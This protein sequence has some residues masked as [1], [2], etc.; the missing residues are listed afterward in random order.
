MTA[1]RQDAY[2]DGPLSVIRSRVD[3]LGAWLA[4]WAARQEPEPGRRAGQ[5]HHLLG[6][7][8]VWCSDGPAA[9]DCP[10]APAARW[11]FGVAWNTPVTVQEAR[12]ARH[13]HILGCSRGV[14]I[15]LVPR[16][17]PAAGQYQRAGGIAGQMDQQPGQPVPAAG[18]HR[19]AAHP[20]AGCLTSQCWPWRPY[21][22]PLRGTRPWLAHR[23][24]R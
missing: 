6:N 16:R 23:T 1:G 7:L 22:C 13:R 24:V 4:I 14:G 5:I 8:Q 2:D 18:R 12:R 15:R 21:N 9:A 10:G 17:H 20:G 19:R 3:D 11:L